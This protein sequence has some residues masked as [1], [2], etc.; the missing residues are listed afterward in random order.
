MLNLCTNLCLVNI[1]GQNQRLLILGV[2]KLAT[3][4]LLA[5]VLFV[6]FFLLHVDDQVT[7]LGDASPPG[8]LAFETLGRA[9]RK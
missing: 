3:Q 9:A 5:L 6:F 4:V 2:S 1:I 8:E 7:I